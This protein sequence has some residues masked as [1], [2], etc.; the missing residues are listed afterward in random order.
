[1]IGYTTRWDTIAAGAT[2]PYTAVERSPTTQ[3]AS[4]AALA[5][6][7]ADARHGRERL[8]VYEGRDRIARD[9][10]DLVVQRLFATGMLL[11]SAQRRGGP[12]DPAHDS[13]GRAVDE[14]QST[15][16]EVRTAIF[17]LQQP[18]AEA[19]TR[20]R[21]R[22]L[23][24]TAAASATLGLRPSTRFRGPVDTL[25]PDQVATRLLAALRRTLAT[26]SGRPG[27]SRLEITVDV[28]TP[29]PDGRDAVRLTV[30]DD[31][32]TGTTASWRSSLQQGC[33]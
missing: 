33:Q 13:L 3:F 23:R 28:T 30:Y 9:L 27:V 20:L 14:L 8:A 29:L 2:A 19:P 15:I 5:P 1:L 21:G 24:E 31:A 4:Q 22:V 26:A 12:A 17:A 18:P 16:Q 10:H 11:E 7:L 6:V 32:G 25:V